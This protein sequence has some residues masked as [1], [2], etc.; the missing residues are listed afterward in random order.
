MEKYEKYS[1]EYFMEIALQ[2]AQKALLQDEVPIGAVLVIENKIIAKAYNQTEILQDTTAHAE[3]IVITSA[4]QFIGA[5]Y[6]KNATLYVTVEPCIM[7]IG[8]IF[9]SKISKLVYA[10]DDLKIGFNNFEQILNVNN[11]SLFN[12]QLIIKKGVLK[13]P[14]QNLMLEFFKAKRKFK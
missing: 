10:T 1:D 11:V 3:M 9:W 12:F 4:S 8:A 5:K 14:A 13:E 2:E 6:L 7:C